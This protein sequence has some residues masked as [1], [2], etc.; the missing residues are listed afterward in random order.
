MVFKSH[1]KKHT[2]VVNDNDRAVDVWFWTRA[3]IER[4]RPYTAHKKF[5]NTIT[6]TESVASFILVGWYL[7]NQTS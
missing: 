4:G 2:F 7:E 3:A 5:M 1:C 6:S